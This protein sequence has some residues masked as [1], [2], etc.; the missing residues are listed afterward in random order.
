MVPHAQT[1]KFQ[2]YNPISP[3]GFDTVFYRDITRKANCTFNFQN[4]KYSHKIQ[5][6]QITWT[7]QNV[8]ATQN[9]FQNNHYSLLHI[10]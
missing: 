1:L 5:C 10:I 6:T 3:Y 4:I 9:K 8:I 2:R 7:F